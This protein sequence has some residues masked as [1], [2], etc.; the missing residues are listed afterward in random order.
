[1][2]EFLMRLSFLNSLSKSYDGKVISIKVDDILFSELCDY[3]SKTFDRG[4]ESSVNDSGLVS[5]VYDGIEIVR[6]K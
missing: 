6:V 1:M 5:I 3:I 2:A 4:F